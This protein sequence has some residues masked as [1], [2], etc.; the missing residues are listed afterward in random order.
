MRNLVLFACFAVCA[1]CA[2]PVSAATW[3][4]PDKAISVEPPAVPG[5]APIKVSAP[6]LAGWAI[7]DGTVQF[8]IAS[9]P[10]ATGDTLEQGG[11]EERY[12][13]SINGTIVE[14]RDYEVN[15]YAVFGMSLRGTM[16]DKPATVFRSVVVVGDHSY[17][18]LAIGF[19]RD[20]LGSPVAKAF[21]DSLKVLRPASA[22]GA[23]NKNQMRVKPKILPVIG[24][25]ALL[26]LLLFVVVFVAFMAV[27]W[28]RRWWRARP[29]AKELLTNPV[30]VLPVNS[31]PSLEDSAP[32]LPISTPRAE[33]PASVPEIPSSTPIASLPA[34]APAIS[35][36]ISP[37]SPA[38]PPKVL[39]PSVPV[40]PAATASAAPSPIAPANTPATEQ[41]AASPA[42]SRSMPVAPATSAIAT[43]PPSGPANAP[44]KEQPVAPEASPR[45][46]PV[47][48]AASA[49]AT[50]P[51][52]V[53]ASPPA[54]EPAATSPA[55][56]PTPAPKPQS[57]SRAVSRRNVFA[58]WL[59]QGQ[60]AAQK[61]ASTPQKNQPPDKKKQK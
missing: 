39:P 22:D 14:S 35:A 13:K 23:T 61:P 17:M 51:L 55:P 25:W 3:T 29:R 24:Y 32:K 47:V 33:L 21:I 43:C 38:T 28:L 34:A 36:P 5:I 15:G 53:P 12:R 20:I 42:T 56:P 7:K 10:L 9:H 2:V 30:T 46:M 11:V 52:N 45:S 57:S 49:I 37:V 59:V 58:A 44:T 8:L 1:Y 19:G 27:V 18:L 54:N 31:T 26:L 6:M 50:S 40:T 16:N 48:P 41:P 4:S 60:M